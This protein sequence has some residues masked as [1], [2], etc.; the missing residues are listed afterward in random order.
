MAHIFLVE[1]GPILP[2]E[3]GRHVEVG[4]DALEGIYAPGCTSIE[5][6]RISGGS[7]MAGYLDTVSVAQ[8]R[9]AGIVSKV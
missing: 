8:S 7:G 5:H 1:D 6:A 9:P 4:G 3:P 2:K